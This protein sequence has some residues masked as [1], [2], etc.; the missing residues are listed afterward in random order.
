MINLWAN[1]LASEKLTPKSVGEEGT[2]ILL[3]LAEAL[4]KLKVKPC[5]RPYFF[6]QVARRAVVEQ[7][8]NLGIDLP[9]LTTVRGKVAM[10][11]GLLDMW[12]TVYKERF[13]SNYGTNAWFELKRRGVVTKLAKE[14]YEST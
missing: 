13:G 2:Q 12:S 5:R 11:R 9:A 1:F 10:G 8:I 4:A 14:N 3:T 7:A 6:R